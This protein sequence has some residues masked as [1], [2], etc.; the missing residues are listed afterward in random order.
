MISKKYYDVNKRSLPKLVTGEHINY[1]LISKGPRLP[2]KIATC[3]NGPRS[4]VVR[5]PDGVNFIRIKSFT[6]G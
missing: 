2:A 5:T 4:F 1:K 6:K 3:C